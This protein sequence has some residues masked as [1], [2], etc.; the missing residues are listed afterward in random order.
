MSWFSSKKTGVA[1]TDPS[2]PNSTSG[3]G[4]EQD[5]FGSHFSSPNPQSTISD[6]KSSAQD[7]KASAKDHLK[8]AVSSAAAYNGAGAEQDRFGKHWSLDAGEVRVKDAAKAILK[9]QGTGSEQDRLGLHFGM[10]SDGWAR[11]KHIV[12]S[13]AQTQGMGAEQDRYASHFGLDPN[14]ISA[15]KEALGDTIRRN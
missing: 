7:L 13:S 2:A 4:A 5:R 3:S 11:A 15:I 9:K 6:L 12:A 8:S 10:G 14:M 1:T